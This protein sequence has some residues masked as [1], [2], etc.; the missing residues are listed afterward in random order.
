MP[1]AFNLWVLK[2]QL[3]VAQNLNDNA[4]HLQMIR[5][6]QSQIRL[7]RVPLDGWYPDLGL[8]SA[9]FH[10]YQVLPH[11][12]TAYLSNVFGTDLTFRWILYLLLALWPVCVYWT[13][14]LF[15]LD[16]RAAIFAAIVSPLLVSTPAHGYEH[17][18]YTWHGYGVWAQLWGMWL[19]PISWGLTWRAVYE[20]GSYLA[21]SAALAATVACHFLT[22]YLGL[23]TLGLWVLVIPRGMWQHAKRAALVG[24]G[25]LAICSWV[26]VPT[27]LDGKWLTQ[28]AFQRGTYFNDSY[29]A[30]KV[31]GWLFT[32]QIYDTG[33]VA[34][35]TLLVGA[36]LIRCI[37]RWR[38]ESLRAIVS[39]W[40]LS[41]L[42]FF[43]RPTLGP[44]LK[45]LP[46]SSDLLLHRFVIGLHMAGILLAGV[47]ASWLWELGSAAAGSLELTRVPYWVAGALA[48]IL[49]LAPAWLERASYNER[50]ALLLRMQKA[51]DAL[52]GAQAASLID[53]AKRGRD[54]RIYAGMRSN[55]GA[56]YRIGAVPM[57]AALANR[58]ADA[59][60]FTLRTASLS[61]D[62]E[63][64]FDETRPSYYDLFNV[65]YVLLPRGQQP[66]V[67][68]R[69]IRELGRHV[70]W[71]V[72]TT[73]YFSV[74]DT[75]S[76]IAADR[77]NL[78]D[79][80]KLFMDS[81]F[82]ERKLHPTIAFAG[83]PPAEGTLSLDRLNPPGEPGRVESQ[84]NVALRGLYFAQIVANRPAVALLKV[85]YDPRWSVWVDGRPASAEIIAPSFVGVRVPA[86]RHWVRF[87][88]VPF[89]GY[90]LLF[91]FGAAAIAALALADRKRV[92]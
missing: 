83:A 49:F 78:A 1:V 82:P 11:I 15:R 40:L 60:G 55:W 92:L 28:S 52:D 37:G 54:G 7:G 74:V 20:K 65:R 90:P 26:I 43:G 31:L 69:L 14:R 79:K 10:H 68:A 42:L 61:S 4:V 45:L 71:R 18:S 48:G 63:A 51:A 80:V 66:A 67:R 64:W 70:L 84:D 77:T 2:P 44:L 32:G 23:L 87:Q 16:N 89:Q 50:G 36:G 59:I 46:F 19:L 12:L 8:G 56:Q 3:I 75:A 47:G 62:V 76:S 25:T 29:G 91:L 58:D 34:V 39:V 86:G 57:F 35:I 53:E 73:G 38:E 81:R 27:A 30:R 13:A 72:D 85:S 22:G 9:H 24:A 33:R 5:W 41:L 21:A 6:A 17:G 88:Y